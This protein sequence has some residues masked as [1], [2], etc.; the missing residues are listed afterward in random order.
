[1]KR[2][3]CVLVLFG[4]LAGVCGEGNILTGNHASD[5]R[6]DIIWRRNWIARLRECEEY[7][8]KYMSSLPPLKLVY[9]TDLKPGKIDYNNETMPLSFTI[10]LFPAESWFKTITN[11]VRKVQGDLILTGR[12]DAWGIVDPYDAWGPNWPRRSVGPRPY[13]FTGRKGSLAVTVELVN[14]NGLSIG[15]QN[16]ALGYEWIANFEWGPLQVTPKSDTSKTVTF[17]AV[18]ADLITDK[19]SIKVTGIDGFDAE[20]VV[21]NNDITILTETEYKRLLAEEQQRT[22]AAVIQ[23]IAGNLVR[24]PGGTFTMGS[25]VSE[26]GR[27]SEE[28]QHQVTVSSFFMGKYEVTQEEYEI[29]MGDN[30]SNSKGDNLPVTDMYWDRAVEYCNALSKRAGLTPAYTIGDTVTWNRKANGYRL[31]TEAEWEY[32]CRAGTTGPFSTGDTIT[33]NQANYSV[34]NDGDYSYWYTR[35]ERTVDVGSFA[36]NPWGLYD[37]HGNVREWCWD[38]YGIY[39]AGSQT[40]PQGSPKPTWGGTHVF[41]GGSFNY[42]ADYQRSAYRG[43][44]RNGTSYLGFR[45][46]RSG[47]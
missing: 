24:I 27:S 30:P 4:I 35:R 15:S 21:E 32:A 10:S 29:V 46:C 14:E 3:L 16:I 6:N 28:I 39:S 44:D 1:M 19:L 13:P 17:P 23:R 22:E 25:P 37:M 18:K 11:V 47:L 45:V 33:A 34:Y 40:D 38:W 9:S 12:Y 41:R 8:T 7:Y 42:Y 26:P 43:A 31:P 36:P 5:I 20:T 2:V